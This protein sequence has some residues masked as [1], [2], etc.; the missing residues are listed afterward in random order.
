MSIASMSMLFCNERQKKHIAYKK[1]RN[2]ICNCK[3]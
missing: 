1:Y 3:V 2:Q